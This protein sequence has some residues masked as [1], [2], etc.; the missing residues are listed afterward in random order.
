MSDETLHLKPET[1]KLIQKFA[2]ELE[3]KDNPDQAVIRAM[4]TEKF[5]QDQFKNTKTVII[6]NPQTGR[7]TKLTKKNPTS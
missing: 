5:I 7:K 3:L 4:A 6:E 2:E 1:L